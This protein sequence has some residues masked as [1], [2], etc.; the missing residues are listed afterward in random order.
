MVCV[1][2]FHPTE[3]GARPEMGLILEEEIAKVLFPMGKNP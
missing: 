1:Q 2:R 3:G